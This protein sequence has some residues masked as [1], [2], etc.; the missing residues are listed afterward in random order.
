MH[1]RSNAPHTTGSTRTHTDTHIKVKIVFLDITLGVSAG[2]L[3]A[4]DR[5]TEGERGERKEEETERK[6]LT[7]DIHARR[8]LMTRTIFHF[9]F[10]PLKEAAYVCFCAVCM[11][12]YYNATSGVYILRCW[13]WVMHEHVQ[14]CQQ[15]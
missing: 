5:D 10:C 14:V 3:K 1:P 11:Y 13:W 2:N 4:R 7:G 9:H 6:A 12:V 8:Y 15:F